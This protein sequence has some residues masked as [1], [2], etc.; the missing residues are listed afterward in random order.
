MFVR[1]TS[2]ISRSLRNNSKFYSHKSIS[3][4]LVR[5]KNKMNNSSHLVQQPEASEALLLCSSNNSSSSSLRQ[6]VT[7]THNSKEEM[8]RWS[9]T[10]WKEWTIIIAVFGIT[11]STTVRIVR[12]IVTNVFGVEGNY[13]NNNYT[14]YMFY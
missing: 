3:N 2:L 14:S 13:H 9:W 8:K 6:Y 1:T 12:P 7:A 10:W 5:S 11:G 4:L